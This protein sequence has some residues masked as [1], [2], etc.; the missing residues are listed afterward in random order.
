M[1]RFS[2]ETYDAPDGDGHRYVFRPDR[3]TDEDIRGWCN[4]HFGSIEHL[5]EY[6]GELRGSRWAGRHSFWFRDEQDAVAFRL[7]WC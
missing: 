6:L 3:H 5:R 4:E 1:V 2:L 7:R